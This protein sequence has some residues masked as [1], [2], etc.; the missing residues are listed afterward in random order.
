MNQRSIRMKS[1]I[2]LAVNGIPGSTGALRLGHELAVRWGRPLRL[3]TVAEPLF[4]GS[5]VPAGPADVAPD[6][7][8][9]R[10]V[11]Q[12]LR[13]AVEAQVRD[14][15]VAEPSPTVEL[16]V[17]AA[18]PTIAAFAQE[19][20]AAYIVIG[21]EAPSGRWLE[22]HTAQRV[23]HL[24]H[25]PV[26]AV[27]ANATSLPERAVVGMDF[28][29]FSLD[30]ARKAAELLRPGGVLHLLH[31]VWQAPHVVEAAQEAEWLRTYRAGADLRLRE[32]ARD[33]V[34]EGKV[35]VE[36]AFAEGEPARAI[37]TRANE[38]NADL[39]AVGSH[40]HGWFD[41]M[42]LGSVSTR[43]LAEAGCSVLI[44]TPTTTAGGALAALRG[45]TSQPEEMGRAAEGP[46]GN[47]G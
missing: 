28:S 1:P 9:Q 40:G 36:H 2:L 13:H 17:G 42:L 29:S 34:T 10:D 27:V 21:L 25:V 22:R 31:V 15:G 4:L 11:H 38:V 41:R 37:L 20:G 26:L 30:A 8:V 47:A 23:M 24:A 19:I 35:R 7:G 18:A 44:A 3:L 45:S 39:I 5:P 6:L 14:L 33:L 32:I 12:R 16:R 43:V 46:G